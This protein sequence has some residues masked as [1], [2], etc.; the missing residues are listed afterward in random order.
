MEKMSEGQDSSSPRV[1]S[2]MCSHT[3]RKKYFK[4]TYDET[5]S[6]Y[7]FS[8]GTTRKRSQSEIIYSYKDMQNFHSYTQ[9]LR[10]PP[11]KTLDKK[12]DSIN[13][14]N[15]SL[16][17]TRIHEASKSTQNFKTKQD[18]F[19]FHYPDAYV[20]DDDDHTTSYDS[21]ISG[22]APPFF[23]KRNERKPKERLSVSSFEG[24]RCIY[25]NGL[26]RGKK[27]NIVSAY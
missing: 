12:K 17:S 11:Q 18:S 25:D 10:Q 8:S 6:I 26:K 3:Q 13:T 23:L 1:R 14:R 19:F 27:K 7:K 20:F 5:L 21:L 24:L 9:Q 22:K 16:L 4:N 2:S 15:P